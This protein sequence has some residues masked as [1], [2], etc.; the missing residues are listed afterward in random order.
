MS[1]ELVVMKDYAVSQMSSA[2]LREVIQD[3]LGG[4]SIRPSDLDKIKIPSGGSTSWE[5]PD[6]E[7]G[8]IAS[9]IVEGV[10]IYKKNFNAYWAEEY[11]GAGDP[12][13]CYSNDTIEGVG[14]PGGL[15]AKCPLNQWGSGKG[16]NGKACHNKMSLFLLLKNSLL[17]VVL[18]LPPTSMKNAKT[19]F[20]RLA[21]SGIKYSQ[22]LTKIS[23]EKDKSK[24]SIEYSKAV[25]E[26]G[27]KLDEKAQ[28]SVDAYRQG[29][30][31]ALQ[32]ADVA[33]MENEEGKEVPEFD[34]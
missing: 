23:L 13:T 22:A 12:P 16:G 1:K 30:L 9:K 3:N 15:C 17:P 8:T 21:S 19:Y 11:N 34:D 29:I 31:P 4:E 33:M 2:D 14:D 18:T 7:E 27:G 28:E 24:D 6:I 26:F 5:I 10:I 32:Q 25:F 20:M